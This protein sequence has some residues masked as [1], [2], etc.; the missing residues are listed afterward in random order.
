MSES[1]VTI[2]GTLAG[3][4]ATAF[5]ADVASPRRADAL[6][7]DEQIRLRAYQLYRARGGTAGDDWSD[8][9][10]AEREYLERQRPSAASPAEPRVTPTS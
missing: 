2:P 4:V 5:N 10:L 3:E 8:W 1:E 9:L 6:P 7:G